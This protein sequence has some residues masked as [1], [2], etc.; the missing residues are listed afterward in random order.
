MIA[1]TTNQLRLLATMLLALFAIGT[2]A[3]E[4]QQTTV[5]S[6]VFSEGWDA[7]SSGSV[8]TYTPDGSGWKQLANTAWKTK[9]PV[10]LPNTCSGVQKDYQLKLKT[11]DGKWEVKM[12]KDSYLL[13]MN[14]ASTDK[15]TAPTDYTDGTQHDQYFEASFPTTNLNNVNINFAIGDGSSSSTHFGVVYSVDGGQTWSVLSEY[16][17]GSHWNKYVDGK[18]SLDA[19]NKEKVIVRLLVTS[20]TKA[21]NYNL[22][23]FKVLADDNEGP[24]LLYLRV[25]V[26]PTEP[27]T[28]QQAERYTSH[29][30]RA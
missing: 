15:F 8:I 6:W 14:T 10:F 19:N 17:S 26:L 16:V 7:E 13:R 29:T 22:K 4:T 28:W 12:S 9:Q 25:H 11:S 5:A 21:S 1:K 20:A 3:T 23:Y 2:Y 24:V 18:Y 27:Q 30:T